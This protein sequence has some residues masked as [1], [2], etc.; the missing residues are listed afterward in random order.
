MYIKLYRVPSDSFFS[1]KKIEKTGNQY[2]F[3]GTGMSGQSYIGLM[4]TD[5]EVVWIKKMEASSGSAALVDIKAFTSAS[6]QP[7]F[8]LYGFRGNG[9]NKVK[10]FLAKIDIA[11]AIAWA[12]FIYSPE[13][14]EYGKR[15]MLHYDAGSNKQ[16]ALFFGSG[17]VT[18]GTFP[19]VGAVTEDG[20]LLDFQSVGK[21]IYNLQIN[22]FGDSNFMNWKFTLIG[23]I[24]YG[25]LAFTGVVLP[26]NL[27]LTGT[28]LKLSFSPNLILLRTSPVTGHQTLINFTRIQDHYLLISWDSHKDKHLVDLI[29]VST[30]EGSLATF[31]QARFFTTNEESTENDDLLRV[32]RVQ[33]INHDTLGKLAYLHF[34]DRSGNT[35]QTRVCRLTI[36]NNP[37]FNGIFDWV[38]NFDLSHKI[39]GSIQISNDRIL[40]YGTGKDASNAYGGLL[41]LTNID[42]A[43]CKTQNKPQYTIESFP[44]IKV[45]I[46]ATAQPISPIVENPAITWAAIAGQTNEIC[47]P[48]FEIK[49][50][51]L[52]Q[53]PYLHLQ[54]AGSTGTDSSLGIHLR[55]M[56]RRN[57]GN[58]HIPKGNSATNTANFNKPDDF[59]R[60]YRANYTAATTVVKTFNLESEKPMAVDPQVPLWVYKSLGGDQYIYVRFLDKSKYDEI[61]INPKNF[62]FD[63]LTAYGNKIIEIEFRDTLL[64]SADFQVQAT[65]IYSLQVE[66]LSA[67]GNI[68]LPEKHLSARV[69][70]SQSSASRRIVSENIS[71]L[72]CRLSSGTLKRIDY[73]RYSDFLNKAVS[74]SNIQVLSNFSLTLNNTEAYTRLE[75]S[76]RFTVQNAWKK[77]NDHAKVKVQNYKDRW[78]AV[79]GALEGVTKY[80]H[81][82]NT[83][84]LNV[85]AELKPPPDDTQDLRNFRKVSY[86]DMLQLIS[87]DYHVARMLGLGYVDTPPG[88]N[89]T[90]Y[91]YLSEYNT[92]GE[93]DDGLGARPV[94]HLYLSLPTA[95]KDE[96]LPAPIE[97]AQLKYGL[98][99][100]ENTPHPVQ[101]TNDQGYLPE[102]DVRYIRLYAR[103]VTAYDLAS[104]FFQADTPLFQTS[105]FTHPVFLG[106]EYKKQS[107]SNWRAPEIA[108]DSV[109]TDASNAV[110]ET[111]PIPFSDDP[112]K[113]VLIHKEMEAGIHE[114]AA[115]AINIFSRASAL[116]PKVA[117]DNTQF[118]KRNSLMPP[119]DFRVQLI[120]PES[121][122]LTLTT[123][124]EQSLL[125][126][127]GGTDKTLVRVS[128]NYTHIHDANY[129]FG[130]RVDLFFR[131]ELPRN[132]AGSVSSI[133]VGTSPNLVIVKTDKYTYQSA[134]P[135][136]TDIPTLPSALKD[137]F[138][139]GVLVLGES[140]YIIEEIE[141]DG[142][143][144]TAQDKP[145][146]TIRKNEAR[147]MATDG[148]GGQAITPGLIGP[149]PTM[150]VGKR[151]MVI[152]NMAR[153]GSWPATNPLAFSVN[154]GSNQWTTQNDLF[155]GKSTPLRG[156]WAKAKCQS[157]QGQTGYYQIEFNAFS[158]T[159][160]GQ[161]GAPNKVEWFK[162]VVRI[163][164]KQGQMGEKKAFDVISIVSLSPLKLLIFDD[165]GLTPFFDQSLLIDVNY[166][167]G[168]RCYLFA[169]TPKG[170]TAAA[171]LPPTGTVNK[172]TL[173]G[174]RSADTSNAYTS[175]VGVPA[176]LMAQEIVQPVLPQLPVGP[177]YAT[178]PDIYNK[179]TYTFSTAFPSEPYA[180]MFYRADLNSLLRLVYKPKTIDNIRIGLGKLGQDPNFALRWSEFV[181]I[182]SNN[183]SDYT[184]FPAVGGFKFPWPDN[185]DYGFNGTKSPGNL[186]NDLAVGGGKEQFQKAMYDAF[187]PLTKQPLFYKTDVVEP[188]QK[189][190]PGHPAK[191]VAGSG[192]LTVRFTDF[193][194]DGG[195][196]T[197]YLY[198]CRTMGNRMAL[199]EPSPI[200]GPVQ[201]INTRPPEAPV[202]RKVTSQLEDII[203]STPT[204][205]VFEVN[206]FSAYDNI[207]KVA[208][209]RAANA[210]DAMFIKSMK[211][212]KTI[213]LSA[214]D[215]QN[216]ITIF[217][218][219][220]TDLQEIPFGDPLY[221]RLIALR[222]I[223]YSDPAGNSVTD[224]V[225]SLPTKTLLANVIS[226][227][228]PEPPEI[229]FIAA[230]T[231]ATSLSGV[232]LRWNKT[233]YNG[234]Y[235][236]FKM[237][238]AGQ[239][240]KIHNLQS[241]MNSI[242]VNL[243]ATTLNSNVLSLVD[244][245]GERIYHRF[246]VSVES[247]GGL[248]N[249]YDQILTI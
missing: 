110:K 130:N 165:G 151:F 238:N 230:T 224:N 206:E 205:V 156:I 27:S 139:G 41:A 226:T 184:S 95:R 152:E 25:P 123:Q 33:V 36:G 212:A 210:S 243:S 145:I 84:P 72:R 98:I 131:P 9:T 164:P 3:L 53:S 81:I 69:E 149:N 180:L 7:S 73:E 147:P 136:K 133:T 141:Y 195:M 183:A 168:Y 111:L 35:T 225:P 125:G 23:T 202:I 236:L 235:T 77:Y 216:G 229:I 116:S 174:A 113:P 5:F 62:P 234:K 128:F 74:E 159:Q 88:D 173:M 142:N 18:A 148:N 101:L 239:W 124:T 188:N 198:C 232:T 99:V 48:S 163:P 85:R 100:Q 56:L 191:K 207:R 214:G 197:V 127:I 135:V 20:V 30:L 80:I 153:A 11:G 154:I 34:H 246:K 223:N 126:V 40:E 118:V 52:L 182:V 45:Q 54:A 16:I 26:F 121:A 247:T 106:V 161:N 14:K 213:M 208:I 132:V 109:Y 76:S 96:R 6:G 186:K 1:I 138:I 39:N 15:M 170:F 71:I 189:I 193:S 222:E 215:T 55:W 60:I 79:G 22:D 166:Y 150:D 92:V 177:L 241:N 181:A 13:S 104:S 46:T 155:N 122:P 68:A 89:N 91:I 93:L 86:L 38:K 233:T 119:S 87:M 140:R 90:T 19:E 67:E 43:S 227:L 44:W 112:A 196:N 185:P 160:H 8:F 194:I 107:E 220:F 228:N 59:V 192:A 117:T 42:F 244:Q 242:S 82:T 51:N 12:K 144:L 249:L 102:G 63:F 237:T 176:V 94:Q 49:S 179:S 200:L 50:N 32:F 103:L 231:T 178:P 83:E 167:P 209:Y 58:T 169:E 158:L 115:Y 28:T 47:A 31:G 143:T 217:K 4:S 64:F 2:F 97:I 120:Q 65:G 78:T 221:Y 172:N 134:N 70:F 187:T 57:L 66:T 190:E 201:L 21:D 75:D 37:A 137:N 162:G 29:A 105:L 175:P 61:N 218:D 146:F 171:T 240:M 129:N 248:L 10:Y 108:H 204:A 245:D 157:V 199:S 219:D 24:W 114:Y 211:L 203:A 17:K